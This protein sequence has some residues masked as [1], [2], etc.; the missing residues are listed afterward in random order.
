MSQVWPYIPRLGASESLSW[1]TDV[2]QS[3]TTED[4]IALRVPRQAFGLSFSFNDEQMAKAEFAYRSNPYG[5]WLL[6][7]WP[8]RSFVSGVASADVT[9]AADTD[10]DYR[11][12]G[13]AVIWSGD[14]AVTVIQIDTVGAGV[15]NLSAP[16]GADHAEAVVAPL[17]RAY[18]PGGMDATRRH[19]GLTDVSMQWLV[20]DNAEIPETPFDQYLGLDVM[21]D[22]AVI[23]KGLSGRLVY[24]VVMVDNGF[25]P[26][27]VETVRDVMRG[28]HSAYFVDATRAAAWR[29]KKWLYY[30][31]GRQRAFWLPTWA[32]DL[33]LALPITAAGNFITVEPVLPLPADYVGRHLMIWDGLN[34]Y[35]RQITNAILSAGNHRLYM[36]PIGADIAEARLSFMN[37]VRSDADTVTIEHVDGFM[38]NCDLQMVEVA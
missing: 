10:A 35:Y 21:S 8:E 34:F 32:D 33:V 36:S 1:L 20:L 24:P 7:A 29:R 28:R 6:P 26:A 22:P 14:D 31:A 27:A 30:L 5:E 25:G 2:L 16:V 17:R 38:A 13:Q 18:C 11:D 4:R 12:G 15:L 37:K 9:V 19:H 23:T 3:R